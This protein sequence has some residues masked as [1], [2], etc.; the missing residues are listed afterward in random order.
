MRILPKNTKMDKNGP[1]GPFFGPKFFWGI[2]FFFEGGFNKFPRII[3]V[4]SFFWG[5][6][7]V[8]LIWENIFFSKKKFMFWVSRVGEGWSLTNERP[9]TDHVISVP[10]R[11]LE[12]TATDVRNTH[13][14]TATHHITSG[15]CNSITELAQWGRFSENMELPRSCLRIVWNTSEDFK[16][17]GLLYAGLLVYILNLLG[18]LQSS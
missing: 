12:K 1:R 4:V 7:G 13:L 9:R 5:R 10:M 16:C 15:H 2:K 11:G 18:L 17:N 8:Q 14:D 6:R 3:W